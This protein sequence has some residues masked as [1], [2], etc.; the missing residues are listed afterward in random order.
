MLGQLYRPK[1]KALEHA[2][3]VLETEEPHAVNVAWGCSIGCRYCYGPQFSRQTR[4]N[5]MKVRYPKE[6]PVELVKKQ[7]A[8]SPIVKGAEV[9][10]VFISFMTDPYLA[11]ARKL[12]EPLIKY[13][14]D[15]G[16]KV[17]TSSK[18][19]VSDVP[20]VRNGMT[21]LSLGLYEV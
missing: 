9:K 1:T 20:G 21:I 10:G 5:W 3:I 18:L 19:E 14:I 11:L 16:I 15:Q 13:L 8:K 7:L 6:Y 12:T 2:R 17:A 4:E